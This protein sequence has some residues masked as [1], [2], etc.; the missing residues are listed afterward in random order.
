MENNVKKKWIDR[1]PSTVV[2]LLSTLII[3]TVMSYIVPA[4][5]YDRVTDAVT[6][7]TKVDPNSFHYIENQPTS[8]WEMFKSVYT[9][10]VEGGNITFMVLFGYY[11]VYTLVKSGTFYSGISVLLSKGGFFKKYYIAIFSILF[12]LAGSVYGELT[13]TYGLLPMFI[14]IATLM[15]HDAI[16][17][18]AVC[19]MA[20]AIGSAAATTNPYT[21]AIA[22]NVAELPLFSGI[23]YRWICFAVFVP[24]SIWYTMRYAKKVEKNPSASVVSDLNF[25]HYAIKDEDIKDK[26]FTGKQKLILLV[27]LLSIVAIVVGSIKFNFGLAEVATVFIIGSIIMSVVAGYNADEIAKNFVDS[28]YDVLMVVILIGLARSIFIILQNSKIIDTIIYALYQPIKN[29]P[30]G[31]AAVGMLIMQTIINFF[32]PSGSGQAVTIMPIM[33]PLADLLEVKRQIAVLAFHFGDGFSN[34]LWPTAHV[35]IMLGVTKIPFGRWA[36]FFLPLFGIYILVQSA[37]VYIAV[38]IQYGPF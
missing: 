32:I 18:M 4:G 36:K 29:L 1:I 23:G 38:I 8:I 31:P 34:L 5:E 6:N 19:G 16:V 11:W 22:Q 15:G 37:L 17:G 12:A 24:I 28:S 21:L 20:C 27:F 26:E 25:D 10:F 35:G 14:G 9:G 13:A 33:V 2:F 30:P 3:A 7:V